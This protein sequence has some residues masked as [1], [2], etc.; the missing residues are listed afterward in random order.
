MGAS[1]RTL[2]SGRASPRSTA[3]VS[4]TGQM[5]MS[6]CMSVQPG[7]GIHGGAGRVEQTNGAAAVFFKCHELH[8]VRAPSKIDTGS[9]MCTQK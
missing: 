5:P 1:S 6:A 4:S 7:T 2:S 3:A 8:S 9:W